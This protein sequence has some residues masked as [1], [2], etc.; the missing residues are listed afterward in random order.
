MS[1]MNVCEIFF[2][3]N[4]FFSMCRLV[5]VLFR[6]TDSTVQ[7]RCRYQIGSTV[8]VSETD[9]SGLFLCH[10]PPQA[11][12]YLKLRWLVWPPGTGSVALSEGR[13]L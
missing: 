1:V 12:P 11:P 10:P 8:P 6:F 3:F 5:T 4:V 7:Y 13:T 2:T 9:S